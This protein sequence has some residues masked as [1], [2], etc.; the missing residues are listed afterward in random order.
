MAVYCRWDKFSAAGERVWGHRSGG[1]CST[2]LTARYASRSESSM[3]AFTHSLLQCRL[4]LLLLLLKPP[5]ETVSVPMNEMCLLFRE[6]HCDDTVSFAAYDL[7][8]VDKYF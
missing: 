2:Q 8:T 6:N 3:H 1:R 7:H 5:R 4:S